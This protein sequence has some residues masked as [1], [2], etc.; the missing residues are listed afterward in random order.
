MVW[1]RDSEPTYFSVVEQSATVL[2]CVLIDLQNMAHSKNLRLSNS[3]LEVPLKCR[4]KAK[5]IGATKITPMV[6][7]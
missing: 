3:K 6:L 2:H 1:P 7:D 4:L 5:S